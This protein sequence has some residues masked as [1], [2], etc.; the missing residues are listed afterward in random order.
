MEVILFHPGDYGAPYFDGAP[1]HFR[2]YLERVRTLCA[3]F[4]ASE[5]VLITCTI[6]YAILSDK[7]DGVY[8]GE[9]WKEHRPN[10][11]DFIYLIAEMYPGVSLDGFFDGPTSYTFP[12]VSPNI[13]R[14]GPPPRIPDD[15]DASNPCYIDVDSPEFHRVKSE[16]IPPLPRTSAPLVEPSVLDSD[17]EIPDVSLEEPA[18]LDSNSA[19]P[20]ESSC[21]SDVLPAVPEPSPMISPASHTAFANDIVYRPKKI[22]TDSSKTTRIYNEMWTGDWWHSVQVSLPF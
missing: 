2:A 14:F 13:F 17:S 15:P 22:F 19:I 1:E 9:I 12:D 3:H 6:A 10:Y 11:R 5:E 18:L 21:I 20:D 4:K 16:P 7:E 8:W